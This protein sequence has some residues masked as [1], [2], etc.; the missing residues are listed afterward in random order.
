MKSDTITDTL[1]RLAAKF[2]KINIAFDQTFDYSNS[3]NVQADF[4]TNDTIEGGGD[5]AYEFEE[6]EE[7]EEVEYQDEY[8]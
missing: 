7:E 4:E 5:G 1:S 6:E 3:S 8:E 2:E